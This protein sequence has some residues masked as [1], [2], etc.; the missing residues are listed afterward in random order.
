M[1]ERGRHRLGLLVAGAVLAAFGVSVPLAGIEPGLVGEVA[2]PQPMDADDPQRL[3]PAIRR[4][5]EGPLIVVE[6]VEP[7]EAIHELGGGA[8]GE[9]QRRRPGFRA[10]LAA[11]GTRRP[12]C[13]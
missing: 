9:A 7:A 5:A 6:Q 13:A 8:A 2:L 3:A 12:R 11:G 10:S 4:Q 1:A